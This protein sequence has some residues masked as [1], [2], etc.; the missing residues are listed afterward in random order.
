MKISLGKIRALFVTAALLAGL[1]G[2]AFSQTR[3][4]ITV[5]APLPIELPSKESIPNVLM[6]RGGGT[7]EKSI[8]VDPRVSVSLCVTQGNVKING[9]ARNEV[10]V[11][12]KDGSKIGFS[13][14]EKKPRSET[15]V[16]IKIVGFDPVKPKTPKECLWGDAVE[17]DAPIGA[18][19]NFE[20]KA[21]RT[22]VDSVRKITVNN[23]GG[24][25]SIRNIAE[26]VDATTYQGGV[27]V[28]NSNGMITLNTTTGNILAF[29]SGP[30]Q[31]GDIFRA[32][33]NSG[34]ISLQNLKHRQVEVNSISGSVQFIGSLLNG[35]IYNIEKSKGSIEL[36]IPIDSPCFLS[37]TYGVGNFN[38]ELPIKVIT[39]N[40]SPGPIKSI[41][42]TLGKGD[43]KLN[44][45]NA[46]GT[47]RIRKQ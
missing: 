36:S 14:Q 5:D 12:V 3:T 41:K 46:S 33:T 2:V 17:I 25:I 27:D 18:A 19:V 29:E 10:R 26:G 47:I 8:A 42:G 43:C 23:A 40:V 7:Y 32:R 1:C 39:E 6:H 30:S 15:P 28:E 45:T 21:T 31:V 24:G 44:L 4:P 34:N 35:G 20:G 37:A 22:V 13:I 38:S 9:W 16:W 11:F